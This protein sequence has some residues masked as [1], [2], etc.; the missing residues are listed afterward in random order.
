LE[1]KTATAEIS[2]MDAR[3]EGLYEFGREIVARYSSLC[4]LILSIASLMVSLREVGF[5]FI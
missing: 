3:D 5:T 4:G 2:A 1:G